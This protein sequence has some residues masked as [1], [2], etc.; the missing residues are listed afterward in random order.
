MLGVAPG[1][2]VLDVPEPGH[3]QHLPL[4]EGGPAAMVEPIGQRSGEVKAQVLQ[5]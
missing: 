4:S 5:A 1:L 3:L 2:W